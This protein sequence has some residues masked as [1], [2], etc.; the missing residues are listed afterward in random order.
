VGCKN[1]HTFTISSSNPELTRASPEIQ[2][3][4]S[5]FH[6]NLSNTQ[7]DMEKVVLIRALGNARHV[8]SIPII[9]QYLTAIGNEDI[10]TS[11]IY[12]LAKFV[13]APNQS[14]SSPISHF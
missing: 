5:E 3:I 2:R 6:S 10:Q 8:D 11:A 4:I 7:E 13:N 9:S 14:K 12:S 1:L